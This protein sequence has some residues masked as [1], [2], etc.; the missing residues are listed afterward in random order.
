MIFIELII[1]IYRLIDVKLNDTPFSTPFG[2]PGA[3]LL[4]RIIFNPNKDNKL[5]GE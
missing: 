1:Y 3:H 4:T 5:S 2:I